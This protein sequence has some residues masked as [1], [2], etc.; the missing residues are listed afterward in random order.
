[1]ETILQE[2]ENFAREI[3]PEVN[4]SILELRDHAE[5]MLLAVINDMQTNQSEVERHDK[6]V[7]KATPSS[8]SEEIDRTSA[9]HAV[10]RLESGFDIRAL[11]A[12]YRAL[13][14]S[15]LHLWSQT[16]PEMHATQLQDITRFNEC[17]DQLLAE[18]I[19]SYSESVEHSRELLL[20]ILGHDLRSPL[21]TVSMM[22]GLLEE[23]KDLN[24]PSKQMVSLIVVAAR[25][26]TQ[27]VGDLLDF[28]GSHLGSK[29]HVTRQSMNLE[30]L[31]REVIEEIR[32]VHPSRVFELECSGD[33]NGEWDRPRLRQLISNLVGNAVQHGAA[34]TP[35]QLF[36]KADGNS[37]LLRVC[38]Q[39]PAIPRELQTVM[40][41]PRRRSLCNGLSRELGGFGL[42]LYIAREVV[43]AHG[44]VIEVSSDDR[45]T[46]FIVKLPR[47]DLFRKKK[48]HGYV[49]T[50]SDLLSLGNN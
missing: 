14:S 32:A 45:E 3:W 43:K 15:V 11:V 23:N 10:C 28:A 7:G 13:R 22:A 38:N 27:L 42:G 1:M 35:I 36:I 6:S 31:C 47:R 16:V 46:A 19:L 49:E 25:E 12:E 17:V 39:G 18:S 8:A 2:W 4:P 33:G 41:D 30:E 9:R 24:E 34:Q 44:G 5:E 50:V 20:G 26:M 40:F 29:M 21:S 48:T 37:M